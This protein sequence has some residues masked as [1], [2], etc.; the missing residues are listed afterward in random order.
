M[1]AKIK[2]SQVQD[3]LC[4]KRLGRTILHCHE[5]DSTNK[6]AKEL[7]K[8]GASEGTVMVA[9]TQTRG[10]GRHG[11]EWISPTGGL[12]FSLVLRPK[13]SPDVASKLTFVAGLAVVKVLCEMFDLEAETK[14]PNDVLVN[15][16]KICGVISEM[17][18]TDE[19]VNFVVVGIGVNTNFNVKEVFP[20]ELRR[21]ATSLQDELGRKIQ[22]E[23]LFST[24]LETIESLYE[25]FIEEGSDSIL[26]EWKSY[27]RFLGHK[28]EVTTLTEKVSG[29]AL[30]IDPRGALALELEDGTVKHVLTGDVSLQ[31]TL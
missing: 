7:A 8:Y 20:K 31:L 14:W 10:R 24:L 15:K 2:M 1:S 21:V 16:R 9:E 11:R 6:W 28:V 23:E 25:Q 13:L 29:L 18:T 26:E 12:W 3:R 27:A 4:T 22:L 5:I 17:N 30:D 19:T